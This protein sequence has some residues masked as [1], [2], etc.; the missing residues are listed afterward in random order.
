MLQL[1]IY[2]AGLR[3]VIRNA[4]SYAERAAIIDLS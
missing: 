4:L 1:G 3:R 2:G